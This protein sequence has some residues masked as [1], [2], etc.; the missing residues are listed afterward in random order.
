M[1]KKAFLPALALVLSVSAARAGDF[2][3]SSPDLAEGGTLAM[4]QVY[5]GSDCHGGNTAPELDWRNPPAGTRSFA[6]TVYDPD[7]RG[8]AGW[9]HW[10]VY[11]IPASAGGIAGGLPAGARQGANGLGKAGYC[12]AC[13]PP[14]AP[15]RYVFTVHALKVEH[16]EAGADATPAMLG[17]LIDSNSLGRASITARYGR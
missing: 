14:G 2:V 9:W 3:L 8:G 5:D 6:V 15:H 11:D 10:L 13:P 16:L 1:M 4:A 7:A 12:G 17:R